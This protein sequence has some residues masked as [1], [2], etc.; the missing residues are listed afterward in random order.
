MA[1]PIEIPE[2]KPALELLDG[3]LVRKMSPKRRHQTLE[4]RWALALQAWAGDRGEALPEWRYDFQA[5]GHDFASLVPDVAYLSREAL[6]EL[7]PAGAELPQRAPEIAV[8]V[9]SKGDSMRRLARKIDAYLSAGTRVLFVVDPPRRTVVV[10][11]RSAGGENI[12]RTFGPGE[13]VTH[14][15]MPGFAYAI[16]TMFEGLYLGN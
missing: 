1:I 7:G 2:I 4:V 9:I 16:E 14:Q 10:H 15:S 8:E 13:I 11:S 3:Q 12:S 5:P 6:A